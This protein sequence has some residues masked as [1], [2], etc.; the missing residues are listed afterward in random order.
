MEKECGITNN[1]SAA[2]MLYRHPALLGMDGVII[3]NMVD[4]PMHISYGYKV[5]WYL[6]S[7]PGGYPYIQ[8]ITGC[9]GPDHKKERGIV[10][11][12][13]LIMTKNML[14]FPRPRK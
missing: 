10:V 8:H 13:I 14:I 12:T 1:A 5:M 6:S 9:S 3:M 2:S 11:R 4:N 7:I